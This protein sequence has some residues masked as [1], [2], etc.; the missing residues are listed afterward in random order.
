MQV[1]NEE[2]RTVREFVREPTS[3]LDLLES[4][5]L[6][7]IILTQKGKPRAVIVSVEE[8]EKSHDT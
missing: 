1:R 6:D 7:K 4:K 2:L 8:Y 3:C 5:N